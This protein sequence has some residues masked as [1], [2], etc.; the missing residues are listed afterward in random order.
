MA[1]LHHPLRE[2]DA[3][4]LLGRFLRDH[5]K[6]QR[7]LADQVGVQEQAVTAWKKRQF[8]PR[9]R[10]IQRI[11]EITGGAV[12]PEAWFDLGPTPQPVAAE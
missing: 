2:Q 9:L 10:H 7:W 8:K 1:D 4:A 12:P 6:T 3:I 5:G 11:T